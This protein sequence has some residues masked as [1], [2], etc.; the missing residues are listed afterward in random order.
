M[1]WSCGEREK[2]QYRQ[3]LCDEFGKRWLGVENLRLCGRSSAFT[4]RGEGD[5]RVAASR[6]SPSV[7]LLVVE[8]NRDNSSELQLYQVDEVWATGE[9]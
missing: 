3:R 5:T 1:D 8:N 4:V 2:Q 6:V 9:P 7:L